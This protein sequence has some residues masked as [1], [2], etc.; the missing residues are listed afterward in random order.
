MVKAA[1]P[2]CPFGSMLVCMKWLDSLGIELTFNQQRLTCQISGN[3]LFV[4]AV[5]WLP[6]LAALFYGHIR[7]M[8]YSYQ[9]HLDPMTATRPLEDD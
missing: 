9:Y 1:L 4:M 8:V 3:A 6:T 5:L 7:V 2:V